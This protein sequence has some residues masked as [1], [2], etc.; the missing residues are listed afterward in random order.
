MILNKTP[1]TLA[2]VKENVKDVENKA[3]E[4][5]IKAFAKLSKS[6]VVKCTEAITAL[7]N[8]KIK[9]ENIVKI[10]DFLPK[11]S[12]DLNKIFLDVA[13]SEEESNAI[14]DIIKKY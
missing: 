11:D 6:D 3:M 4:D 12:E 5:Y 1:I 8:P 2:E 9:E 13:L 10:L 14:L 7:N